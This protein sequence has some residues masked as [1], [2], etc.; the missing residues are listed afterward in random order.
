MHM[1]RVVIA[2]SPYLYGYI[3]VLGVHSFL[4]TTATQSVV[5]SYLVDRLC[6]GQEKYTIYL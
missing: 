2:R 1:Y 4:S 6:D 5:L 3:V